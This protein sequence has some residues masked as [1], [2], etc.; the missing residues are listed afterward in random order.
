MPESIPSPPMRE[1]TWRG[2]ESGDG[3]WGRDLRGFN[4]ATV[5]AGVRGL[6]L[7]GRSLHNLMSRDL[8][9]LDECLPTARAARFDNNL[10]G[11]IRF[12]VPWGVM[13]LDLARGRGG[14][15]IDEIPCFV[16][17]PPSLSSKIK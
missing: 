4:G 11:G 1:A 3:L 9:S 14:N 16:H 7:L 6:A 8:L 2:S 15:P 5:A 13:R 17:S 12:F 10:K